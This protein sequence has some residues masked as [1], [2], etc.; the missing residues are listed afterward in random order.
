MEAW[1][2][3]HE[4]L[5]Q[6]ARDYERA[7][8]LN[9]RSDGNWLELARIHERRGEIAQARNAYEKAQSCHPQSAQVAWSYGNFLLRRG[10]ASGAS[11]QLRK[12]LVTAP[13]LTNHAVALWREK[14]LSTSEP[15][16]SLLPRKSLYYLKAIDYLAGQNDTDTALRVW[17]ELLR[18]GQ[19]VEMPEDVPFIDELI[20][21]GR[22][23]DARG[24]WDRAL[25]MSGWPRD[26]E[27]QSSLVFDGGFEHDFANGGF[28]WREAKSEDAVFD[29]DTAVAHSGRRSLRISFS[30][31]SNLDFHGVFEYVPVEP[32]RRYR[33]VA[34]LRSSGLST[35]GGIR[36]VIVDALRPAAQEIL[37]E[38]VTGT[39]P[40]TRIEREFEAGPETR[41]VR[42]VLR[43]LPS[44][45]LDNKLRGTVWVD[46][47]SVVPLAS[48]DW[49]GLP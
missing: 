49:N 33:F 14:G 28:D 22:I 43:R 11:S 47:V 38:D 24:A 1:S 8:A 12:A 39:R 3:E 48:R 31:R 21:A 23:K 26:V 19:H 20:A 18:L 10:D 40:W 25:E 29:F 36:F 4:D 45:K 9:P 27:G 46:D 5:E 37:T 6:A 13:E 30:G 17:D 15:I 2:F 41:L 7:V 35:E 34:Y 42:V 16:G 32:G 44:L